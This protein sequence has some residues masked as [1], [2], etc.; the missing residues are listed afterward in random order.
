MTEDPA[1]PGLAILRAEMA[2]QS[3]DALIAFDAARGEAAAVAA[4]IRATGRLALLGMGASHWAN[5]MVQPF[6]RAAGI[7]AF[8]EPLSEAL[9]Q[10]PPPGGVTLVVSQSGGSGE[11]E[12]WFSRLSGRA[13]QFGLTLGGGSVLA[14][15]VPSLVAPVEK[16]RAFAATRSIIVTLALHAAILDALGHDT[17]PL[18]DL[19]REDAPPPA[20]PAEAVAAL[21]SC[22]A[23]VLSSRLPLH[24][25]LE[26]TALTF[27]ELARLPALA[28]ELGQL[29]H[30]PMEALSPG[31]AL[32]LARPAGADGDAVAGVARSAVDLGLNPVLFD[33]S[34]EEPVAGAVT[35]PLP[36]RDG[37]AA[38]AALLPAAQTLAIQ[39]A[40]RRVGDGFG[41]PLRSS[42]V[43]DGERP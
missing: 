33:L 40:A 2:R 7:M 23:L 24:A 3:R 21:A 32:V 26:A 37:L 22:H 35:I 13:D 5:R 27:M 43:S 8:A 31:L 38:V 6:Y 28:P 17:A 15:A 4:R 34:G 36:P 11:V 14:R 19:W 9:R 39:A 41:R 29:L 25:A 10:P 16:E 20:P 1:A 42:K 30:G 18:L 12:A